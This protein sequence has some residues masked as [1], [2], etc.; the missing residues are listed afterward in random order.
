MVSQHPRPGSVSVGV[1][2]P[3][4]K[5]STFSSK[6]TKICEKPLARASEVAGPRKKPQ[7][8]GCSWRA[9][10]GQE[11]YLWAPGE[12][13]GRPS[14]TQGLPAGGPPPPSE[15]C[16]E[17]SASGRSSGVSCRKPSCLCR[18]E[19][20]PS[21]WLTGGHRGPSPQPQALPRGSAHTQVRPVKV[22]PVIHAG[23]TRKETFGFSGQ[24]GKRLE[25]S[26]ANLAVRCRKAV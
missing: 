11:G 2:R 8:P 7:E 4:P 23:A 9:L 16:P 13:Q 15:G 26:A 14:P 5:H 21:A 22:R 24:R 17:A 12:G 18:A 19:P 20:R 3:H 1:C 10:S 6:T 25:R